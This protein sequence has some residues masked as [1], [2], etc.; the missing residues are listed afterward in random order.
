MALESC[1]GSTGS[2]AA[3]GAGNSRFI[4]LRQILSQAKVGFS[5]HRQKHS[6]PG[7]PLIWFAEHEHW[8]FQ[9]RN[10]PTGLLLYPV[11]IQRHR[12]H[13]RHYVPVHD[14]YPHL[15]LR[16]LVWKERDAKMDG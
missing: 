15:F 2:P 3:G 4:V 14:R 5:G 7:H 8:H 12:H 11:T 16:A 13:P 9:R 6:F 10:M 1:S